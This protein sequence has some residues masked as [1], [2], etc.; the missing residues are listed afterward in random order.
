[1][2]PKNLV[3]LGSTGSI[4]KSTLEVIR[5]HPGTFV[6]RALAAHSNVELL[7]QQYHEFKPE[8]LGLAD[9]TKL[10]QLKSLL[11]DEKV[12][13]VVGEEELV[14]L[15]SI[16]MVDVVVN[17]IVGAAGLLASLQTINMG[18]T[19]AVANKESLVCGGPLFRQ[20]IPKTKANVLPIDSEH[21]AI[22]QAL[23]AGKE[24]E[25]KKIIIT[26]SGG[27]FRTLPKEQFEQ[28]TKKEALNHPTWNMGAKITIDSATLANKGLEVIEATVLF[29]VPVDKVEVVV[30]P[31][32]IIHSMVE[33]VDSSVIA[34][35]S[36]PDMK[37]PISYALFWPERRQSAFGKIDWNKMKE[38]TF[39]QADMEKFPALKLAFEVAKTGGTAPAVFNAANEIA[40]AAFLNDEIK[41]VH[42]PE[43]IR[44]TVEAAELV[45]LPDLN[46]I[47]AADKRAREIAQTRIKE[48][49]CS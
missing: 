4:G 11:K 33:F 10:D 22:W 16:M 26:A 21:S 39:E 47:I 34:Q 28:I 49:V 38:L 32:S 44:Y 19:L 1:M 8:Y 13:I 42:I 25:L 6:V 37:L 12:Q 31:Q 3:I 36:L 41:F 27:P 29:D 2:L 30:H 23:Q 43:I 5:N 14:G 15:T 7:A 45:E 35:L 40:V 17:A 20:I 24:K 18:R 9:E 48:V 46:H